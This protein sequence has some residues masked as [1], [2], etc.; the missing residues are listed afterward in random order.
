MSQFENRDIYVAQKYFTPNFLVYS[1]GSRLVFTSLFN[2]TL[3]T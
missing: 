2:F 1:V 3:V